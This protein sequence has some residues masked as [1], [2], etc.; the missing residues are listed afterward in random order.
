[1]H[2]NGEKGGPYCSCLL[3]AAS[4][5]LSCS[6]VLARFCVEAHACDLETLCKR[7][8]CNNTVQCLVLDNNRVLV[9]NEVRNL[10][11]GNLGLLS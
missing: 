3:C 4:D 6:E 2:V 9:A 10:A 7:W 11:A 1:M 5:V 8:R